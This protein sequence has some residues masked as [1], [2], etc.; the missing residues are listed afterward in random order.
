GAF[1]NSTS[2]GT[3]PTFELSGGSATITTNLLPGGSDSVMAQYAGDGTF[4]P[5][6]SAA[7]D[8]TV[9]KESSQT[10]ISLWTYDSEDGL[11]DIAAPNPVVYGTT[12]YIM[13]VDVTNAA[14]PLQPCDANEVPCPTGTITET[15]D[16]GQKLNDFPNAQTGVSTNTATLNSI[17]FLEDLPINLP[18][19][20][21][22]VVAAYSGDTSYNASTSSAFSVTVTPASTTASVLS[23]SGSVMTGAGVTLT[24]LVATTSTS[25]TGPT[26]TVTFYNKGV[27]MG[28]PVQVT[29]IGATQTFYAGATAVLNTSFSTPGSESIT[30]QYN[31]TGDTNYTASAIS[32]PPVPI[33]VTG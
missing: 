16:G 18:G 9:T 5:A 27:A 15:Y 20:A 14:I 28:T 4:A 22:T 12:P 26:G 33:T 7:V 24:A 29:S 19:G 31:N 6:T 11:Y 3:L 13:R 1:T 17:G 23:S 2:S 21:N 30:A 25:T 32:S 10:T 8:V